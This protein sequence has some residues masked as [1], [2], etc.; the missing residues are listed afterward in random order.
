MDDK[1]NS[2]YVKYFEYE[3]GN[4][5]WVAT[6]DMDNHKECPNCYCVFTKNANI[7]IKKRNG[8]VVSRFYKCPSCGCRI[9]VIS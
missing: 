4:Y 1:G 9:K 3:N 2:S 6:I 5:V 7:C 8:C